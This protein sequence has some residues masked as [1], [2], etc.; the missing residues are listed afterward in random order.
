MTMLRNISYK[1]NMINFSAWRLHMQG[2]FEGL[3][4][5][6]SGLIE[7]LLPPPRTGP[8]RPETPALKVLNTIL[9]VLINGAEWCSVPAGEQW[10]P[11]STAH[12]RPGKW[13]EDGTWCEIFSRL[14]GIA[15]L[16]AL[17]GW[18]R[19][20]AGGMSVPGKGG[21]DGADRGYKGK[22]LTVHAP[23]GGNGMPLSATSAGA[24]GSEREQAET[25]LD[26]I[27][28]RTGRAG[29]PKK[30]PRALQAGKGYDSRDLRNRIRRRGIS[31]MIPRRSWP[32]RRQPAG[33]PPSKPADRWKA[34]RTFARLQTKFRR[35]TVRW[36]RRDRY[37][38][39]FLCPGL[40]MLWVERILSSS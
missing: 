29:R 11:K 23:A 2:R 13:R 18:N 27:E 5:T 15:E 33:R 4:E 14:C 24:A 35:L 25:L 39:G 7:P 3:S 22:G 6:Q 30:R 9:R 12:D 36:E 26:T 16:S 31:P 8:G 38:P 20:S 40:C 28:I 37:R 1:I 17:I 32:D 10:S 19:A 21:G 34:G